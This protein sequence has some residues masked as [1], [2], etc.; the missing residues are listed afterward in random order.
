[1]PVTWDRLTCTVVAPSSCS[2]SFICLFPQDLQDVTP[3]RFSEGFWL[4]TAGF[5]R[6]VF[7][8]KWT[9]FKKCYISRQGT[10]AHLGHFICLFLLQVFSGLNIRIILKDLPHWLQAA[11]GVQFHYTFRSTHHLNKLMS[12]VFLA[13]ETQRK[14][15]IQTN[16]YLADLIWIQNSSTASQQLVKTNIE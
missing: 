16:V 10:P 4:H 14:K 12:F 1:M 6:F 9:P 7:L 8:W 5:G 2:A 15:K 13:I 3:S 11:A